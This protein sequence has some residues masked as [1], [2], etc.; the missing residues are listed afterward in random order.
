MN[1]DGAHIQGSLWTVN[2]AA[3][4]IN[5][6]SHK[7]PAYKTRPVTCWSGTLILDE[8][9]RFQVDPLTFTVRITHLNELSYLATKNQ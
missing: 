7:F 8:P 3:D 1:P 2:C 6:S 5:G 9:S 4:N